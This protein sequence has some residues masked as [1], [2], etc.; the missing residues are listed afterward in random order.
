MTT[1]PIVVPPSAGWNK[2]SSW[3]DQGLYE[4]D[5]EK[6]LGFNGNGDFG[7]DSLTLAYPG[8]GTGHITID[9]QILATIATKDFYLAAWGI[10][11][12]PTNLTTSAA[13]EGGST[14]ANSHQ[15]LLSTLKQENRIP[16]LFY[17][18][19]AGASHGLS[20]G[21]IAAI[22]IGS[23]IFL[24][25]VIIF[26][27]LIWRRT[28]ESSQ[29]PALA[30]SDDSDKSSETVHAVNSVSEHELHAEPKPPAELHAV[31]MGPFEMADAVVPAAEVASSSENALSERIT[32]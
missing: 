17:G 27:I 15:S 4:L 11:P 30:Q 26:S 8:S 12:R 10:A 1:A 32:R 23:A 18:Y 19:T 14:F 31:S 22:A 2:S 5:Q 9:N 16:S 7:L 21:I 6:N 29:V 28:F 20:P 25:T 3:Q 24:V 13:S